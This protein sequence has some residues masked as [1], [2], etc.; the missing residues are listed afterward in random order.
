MALKVNGKTISQNEIEAEVQRIATYRRQ[1]GMPDAANLAPGENSRGALIEE[2]KTNLVNRILLEEEAS[3]RFKTIPREELDAAYD[4]AYG[5]VSPKQLKKNKAEID[6]RR[7]R[8]K[9][10]LR[11]SRL[12]AELTQDIEEPTEKDLHDEFMRRCHLF[13]K[14]ARAHASHIVKHTNEGQNPE[15]ARK[16]IE[17]AYEDLKSGTPFAKVAEKH[18]DCNGRSGDLGWFPRGQM[19]ESFEKVVFALNPGEMSDIFETEF[20]FHIA[21]LHEKE[22]AEMVPFDDVSE[23]LQQD[24]M[25]ERTDGA[26]EGF[27][28]KLREVAEINS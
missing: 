19:V 13:S 15:E 20:G 27:V 9:N 18:S 10:Y 8:V 26:I 2:A 12:L 23:R 5:K 11:V 4:N 25:R 21:L 1:A 3:K 22:D 17:E 24:L 7:Q 6:K 14:P 16:L 28:Q